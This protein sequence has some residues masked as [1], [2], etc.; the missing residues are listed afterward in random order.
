MCVINR[1]IT[2]G[3]LRMLPELLA[4]ARRGMPREVGLRSPEQR[5]VR[6]GHIVSAPD[7]ADTPTMT[8]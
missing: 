1:K 7:P 8:R 6:T 2:S 5:A 4:V 3:S